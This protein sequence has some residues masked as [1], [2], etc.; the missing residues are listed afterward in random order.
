LDIVVATVGGGHGFKPLLMLDAETFR[1]QFQR[2]VISAFLAV[3]TAVPLMEPGG[4]IVCISSN[5]GKM[6]FAYLAGYHTAKG[7]LENFVRAAAEELGPAGIR[8]NAVRPG[9]TRADRTGHLFE[10]EILAKF[11]AEYPLGRA[12]EPDDIGAAVR[13]LAGPESSW[14]TGQSFAADGGQELRKNPDLSELVARNFG[15]GALDAARRGKPY[16]DTNE[17]R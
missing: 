14:M 16:D 15:Q 7:G 17:S 13:F 12:G 9:L 4:A 6:P 2:N 11:V 1:A 8:I 10:A 5:A 3:R